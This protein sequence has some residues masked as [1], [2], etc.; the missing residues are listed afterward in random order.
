MT[1]KAGAPSDSESRRMLKAGEDA[2]PMLWLPSRD[3]E[4]ESV[5]VSATAASVRRASKGA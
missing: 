4:Q 2:L 5:G 3:P 1:E